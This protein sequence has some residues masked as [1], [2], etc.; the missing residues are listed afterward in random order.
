M[1]ELRQNFATKEWV[2]IA[3]ERA[4]R[5]KE[6][7][8]PEPP[9]A[10]ASF[11][12]TCPFCPGNE[13]KTPPEILRVPD[14]SG[15]QVRVVANKFAAL[16]RDA[17]LTRTIHRSRRSIGGF[18]VHD[19]IIETPDHAQVIALMDDTHVAN[20]LRAYK[21][22]YDEL[23]LDPRI[24][25]ITIFKNHGLDAG[26]S[27]EHP[28]SQLIATP[29]ISSQVRGRFQVA[30][31]HHD[32]FGEC[33]FCQMVEE[34]LAQEDRIV[35]T[36]EHFVALEPFASPTPF[37]T[38]IFPRRHMAN[39]GDISTAEI[40]D[41]AHVLR[42]VLGKLYHGLGN[43]DFNYTLRSAPAELHVVKYFHWYVSIIPRLTRVAGFELGS[44]MFINTVP[45]EAAAEFLR[46]VKTE[47]AAGTAG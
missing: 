21:S 8:R 17:Q 2:I 9:K 23:S 39:F 43:P 40:S 41:L 29:V 42:K 5:P 31:Q 30:L 3:T 7:A 38:H 35:L 46:N 4:K 34:E 1:P 32:D 11:V 20:M 26:T 28:H 12:P 19:V 18:G 25:H 13:S 47:L 27:L 22:R 36:T 45:P 16:A 33:M 37:A 6:L 44:G 10:P 14:G 15:W 24:A